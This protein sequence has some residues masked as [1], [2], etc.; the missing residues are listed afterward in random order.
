MDLRDSSL[1]RRKQCP[2]VNRC[3]YFDMAYCLHHLFSGLLNPE[4][5]VIM[6]LRNVDSYLRV[7]AA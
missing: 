1:L 6:L 3:R 2:A 5:E 7:D 4:D